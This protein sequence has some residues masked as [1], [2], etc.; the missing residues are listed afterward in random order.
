MQINIEGRKWRLLD[1][2]SVFLR[3][4]DV[5]GTDLATNDER[6]FDECEKGV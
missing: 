1:G 4:V 6:G 2:E 5:E 3:K